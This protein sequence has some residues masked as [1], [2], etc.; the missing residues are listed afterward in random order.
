VHA[1]S[2]EGGDKLPA[3][4]D[5]LFG[6]DRELFL[7]HLISKA[8]DFDQSCPSRQPVSFPRRRNCNEGDGRSA[9]PTQPAPGSTETQEAVPVRGHVTGAH[10]FLDLNIAVQGELYL[11]EGELSSTEMSGEL[12]EQT[13]V[14]KKAGFE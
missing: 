10:Q 5:I 14:Q 8:P 13:K 1:H 7:A 3:L 2:F 9:R 12:F 4:T 6:S 11:E